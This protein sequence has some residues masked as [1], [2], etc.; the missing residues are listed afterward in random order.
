MYTIL[1]IA[2]TLYTLCFSAVYRFVV[3]NS[4]TRD[5]YKNKQ[6]MIM[7]QQNMTTNHVMT[8]FLWSVYEPFF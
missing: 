8:L 5:K 3:L 6:Q 2:H 1:N 4:N 7:L